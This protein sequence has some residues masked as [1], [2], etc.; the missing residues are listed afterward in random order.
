MRSRPRLRRVSR[1]R[2]HQLVTRYH[3]EGTAAFE[4]RSR[5]PHTG[6]HAVG[7]ELEEL[8]VRLRK[9][10]SKVGYD[11]G[12]ETIA[13]HLARLTRDNLVS[14]RQTISC[15]SADSR[16]HPRT[17]A[18]ALPVALPPSGWQ[19]LTA[20][21]PS[22]PMKLGWLPERL[23]RLTPA[24]V[25]RHPQR[26][27]PHLLASAVAICEL[28]P[29]RGH[30]TCN[31]TPVEQISR[32][33]HPPLQLTAVVVDRRT[34]PRPPAP[35]DQRPQP[36]N[37][38]LAVGSPPATVTSTSTSNA[39]TAMRHGAVRSIPLRRTGVPRNAPRNPVYSD[40][41][42]RHTPTHPLRLRLRQRTV[43]CRAAG[44]GVGCHGASH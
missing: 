26:P 21:Q 32:G 41:C 28:A 36:L 4:P 44:G 3:G 12:T 16:E 10:L 9:Q 20:R 40:S 11:V 39:N 34:V 13:A 37:G 29:H 1:Q 19:R 23:T 15:T 42:D 27:H 35:A 33:K 7:V 31:D 22:Q 24:P 18:V 2:V 43:R 25:L 17:G 38:A 5:R 8:I 6:P 30:G 14:G